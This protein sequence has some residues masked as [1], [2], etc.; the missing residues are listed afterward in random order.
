MSHETIATRVGKSRVAVTNT[1]R[2]LDASAAVKQALVDGRIP[3][4]TR[5]MLSLSAKAQEHLLNR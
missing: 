3:K 4:V 1:L 5:A 2:L